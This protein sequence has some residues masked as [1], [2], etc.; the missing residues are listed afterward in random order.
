LDH[1]D[2]LNKAIPTPPTKQSFSVGDRVRVS[3]GYFDAK[4]RGAIGT[5]ADTGEAMLELGRATV[6]WVEF[7]ELHPIEV[8][9]VD[10]GAFE[11]GDLRLA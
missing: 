11:A 4:L 10:A 1:E 3:D 8:G 7:D 6:F 9:G 2:A 5:I